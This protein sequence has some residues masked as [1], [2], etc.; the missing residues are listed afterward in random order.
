MLI[1]LPD[2]ELGSPP[3]L[4]PAVDVAMT[5]DAGVEYRPQ[6]LI[7]TGSPITVFD[8]ASGEALLVRYGRA[9]AE[10]GR[11]TLLGHEHR[12]QFEYIDLALVTD[13]T[14]AWC[15]KVGFILTKN[16]TMSFQGV[17]GTDG[18]LDRWAVTFNKY[19]NYF[20]IQRPDDAPG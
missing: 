16:F 2:R 20:A 19:Y 15:A 18:F 12:I 5:G 11:I 14:F 9:G 1:K 17:L 13:R 4:R 3:V 8:Y 7:D 6:A 10:T